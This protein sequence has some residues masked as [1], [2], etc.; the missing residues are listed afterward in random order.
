MTGSRAE[1]LPLAGRGTLLN[2]LLVLLGSSIGLII[3]K[4]INP[5]VMPI[6][7]VSIAVFTLGLGIKMFLGAKNLPL[8]ALA[9]CIGGITGYLLGIHQEVIQLGEVLRKSIGGSDNFSEGFAATF[10]LFCVGPMTILGCLEDAIE[11]KITLLGSKSVL[12]GVTS[13]FFAAAFG[14]ALIA[15]AFALLLFQGILTLLAKPLQK[16][17]G[18]EEALSDLSGTGG[19]ILVLVSVEMMNI[20]KIHA[21]DFLPSII[22]IIIFVK[23]LQSVRAKLEGRKQ[24]KPVATLD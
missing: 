14:P 18:D 10:L 6:A 21:V 11:R 16:L 13:I 17:I 2:F 8:I 19:L 24:I 23:C 15:T 12:D 4:H 3:Q 5:D 9:L 20:Q 22:F 7:E 1:K